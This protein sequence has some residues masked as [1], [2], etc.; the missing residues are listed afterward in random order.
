VPVLYGSATPSLELFHRAETTAGQA[1]GTTLLELPERLDGRVLPEVVL[2]DM[3]RELARGNRSVFSRRLQGEIE[4]RLS[5]SEQVILFLNRRGLATF[6]LCREC[7]HVARCPNCDVSLV[8][9]GLKS[10]MSCHY[11]GYETAPPQTCPACGSRRIRYFGTGTE[12]VEAQTRAVFPEA[13]VERLDFDVAS[14]RGNLARILGSFARGEIDV[15]VGT[16][17]IGKGMDV[18]GVTLVGVIAADTA[19]ALPDFRAAERTFSLVTQVAGRAGRGKTAGLV[20][21]QTYSPEHY[22]LLHAARHDYR[23]FYREELEYRRALRYPPFVHRALIRVMAQSPD[24]ARE[25]STELCA[26]LLQT[27]AVRRAALSEEEVELLGPSPSPF[28]RLQGQ[29]RWNIVL[30]SID[31]FALARTADLLIDTSVPLLRPGVRV[32]VDIDPQEIL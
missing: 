24:E 20:V 12:R 15:L 6:V 21:V 22:A 23:G 29:Y 2:V 26:G 1:D 14:R 18:P 28:A 32:A 8:Y 27:Q 4:I 10:T 5:R 7:G 3:R 13:R 19:L 9:H 11:C 31:P 25:A 16:Q 17:I 30:K